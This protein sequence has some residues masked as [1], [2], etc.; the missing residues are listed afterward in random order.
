MVIEQPPPL[1]IPFSDLI[2]GASAA[3][4]GA[5]VGVQTADGHLLLFLTVPA[6][7]IVVAPLSPF[8]MQ[9]TEGLIEP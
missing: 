2:K 4:I 6:G 5:Y 7:I 1:G 3:T 9:S 8:R